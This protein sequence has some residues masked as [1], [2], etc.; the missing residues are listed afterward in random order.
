MVTSRPLIQTL[1][2]SKT[3]SSDT[4]SFQLQFGSDMTT[5]LATP[6]SS[7][8]IQSA[9]NSLPS[10][11]NVGSVH[12]YIEDTP[13]KLKIIIVF[14]T[15][16][17]NL[18]RV[19]VVNGAGFNPTVDSSI[20]QSPSPVMPF[21]LGFG[22]RVTPDFS[23]TMSTTELKDGVLQLFTTN[24]LRSGGGRKFL[25]DTYDI[26]L[27]NRHSG[28]LDNSVEPYCGRYSLR[29]VSSI[30]LY[31]YSSTFNSF[32]VGENMKL[33]VVG[34]SPTQFRYVSCMSC[35]H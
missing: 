10:V 25:A 19:L 20:T 34:Q 30:P 13:E 29:R 26:N 16:Q 1:Q 33:L 4:V 24:C 6:L 3:N 2:L 11:T 15:T 7:S 12:V 23:L 21:S 9:L 28:T 35:T 27:S 31:I 17:S 5:T 18:P 14:I 32:E 8:E 22:N